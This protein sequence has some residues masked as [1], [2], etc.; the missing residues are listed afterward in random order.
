MA[1]IEDTKTFARELEGNSAQK[2]EPYFSEKEKDLGTQMLNF[3]RLVSPSV[4]AVMGGAQVS[5]ANDFSIDAWA[6]LQNMLKSNF[7]V[8]KNGSLF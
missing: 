7:L 4:Q 8:I 1:S 2:M 5:P 6:K 3:E